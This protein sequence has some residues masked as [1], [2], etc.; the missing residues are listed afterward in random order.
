MEPFES[1][2][3][4]YC[5]FLFCSKLQQQVNIMFFLMFAMICWEK[6]KILVRKSR[7]M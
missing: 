5:T 7:P 3:S 1:Y 6:M 4:L 2:C